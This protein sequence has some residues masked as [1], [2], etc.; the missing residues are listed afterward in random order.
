VSVR[1]SF[2]LSAIGTLVALSGCATSPVTLRQSY[3]APPSR[4]PERTL[5]ATAVPKSDCAI[6]VIALEDSRSDPAFLGVIAGRPVHSPG[7]GA[8]WIGGMLTSGLEAK[9]VSLSRGPADAVANR[10]VMAGARLVTAWVNTTSTSMNGT[11]VVAVRD[12]EGGEEAIYRGAATVMNWASGEGE[13]QSLMDR[14]F[15][16]MLVKLSSDLKARCVT[17]P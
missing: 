1:G 13:I 16:Q 2:A 11:V 15:E 5:A 4:T 9:G 17:G 12:R 3:V 6:H 7:Q 14:A 10:V 8:D